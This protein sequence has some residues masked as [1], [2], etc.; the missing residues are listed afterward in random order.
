V[1]TLSLAFRISVPLSLGESW[2]RKNVQFSKVK[3]R[4]NENQLCT[5]DGKSDWQFKL[6][7]RRQRLS[8]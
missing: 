2:G 1:V 7:E 5:H 8:P 4:N 6:L 3:Q